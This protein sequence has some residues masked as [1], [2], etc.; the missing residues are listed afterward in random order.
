MYGLLQSID[1]QKPHRRSRA[2]GHRRR[3]IHNNIIIYCKPDLPGTVITIF[4]CC[5]YT[6][7]VYI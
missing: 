7:R 3:A 1:A 4:V 2:V 6:Y 5:L